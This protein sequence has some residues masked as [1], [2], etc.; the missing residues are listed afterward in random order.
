M[1]TRAGGYGPLS[2]QAFEGAFIS[3]GGPLS[4]MDAG[5][6]ALVAGAGGCIMG[7]FGFADIEAGT[8]L[9]ART[10][11]AQL[12]GLVIPQAGNWT[13]IFYD[14]ATRAFWRR[15][16]L[17]LT[18]ATDGSFWV[19]FP[20][21]AYAS[22][23]CYADQTDGHAISG[24]AVG[25]EATRWTVASNAAPGCLAQISTTVKFGA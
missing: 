11:A 17:M 15:Q 25:A 7:R 14:E 5:P 21:G 6:G 12:C 22:E 1:L 10:S 13:Q 16:G 2:A 20:G 24:A 9:N 4:T 23:P 19:K 18:L 8:V 3:R